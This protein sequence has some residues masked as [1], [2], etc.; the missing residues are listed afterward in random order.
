M[1]SSQR[2]IALLIT[3][4]FIISITLAVGI[5]LK[6]VNEARDEIEKENFMIQ[7]SVILDDVLKI[8]K[9]MSKEYDVKNDAN[10][11]GFYTF[12]E[13]S[14]FIPFESSG[15]KSSIE[16]SSARSKLNVNAIADVNNTNT[17]EALVEY[18]QSR[19]IDLEYI[20]M[21]FDVIKGKRVEP[22]YR[23]NI[24]YEKPLLFKDS[25]NYISSYENLKEINEFYKL[26]YHDNKID[27]INF[28]NLFY[29]SADSNYTLDFNCITSS[30][31]EVIRPNDNTIVV[32]D[33]IQDEENMQQSSNCNIDFCAS[34]SKT[35]KK[36]LETKYNGTC[37]PQRNINV[38]VEVMQHK[39][40]AKIMF[41]YNMDSKKGS[42]FVYEL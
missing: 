31:K 4:F 39:Q 41:E 25:N 24:F 12:L 33:G 13:E 20:D 38:V 26:S 37:K 30:V 27:K 22:P 23:T 14:A 11:E 3:L 5:G 28:K 6:Q 29:F 21:L 19:M 34:L 10:G 1:R 15:V 16:I 32:D 17:E 9:K 2:G 7:S 42:N 36:E 18:F 40:R 35:E 8:L